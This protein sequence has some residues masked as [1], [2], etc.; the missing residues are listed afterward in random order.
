MAATSAAKTFR[1]KC[2]Q[3]IVPR[4]QACFAFIPHVIMFACFSLAHCWIE[5]T[6]EQSTEVSSF[7]AAIM[8]EVILC[9]KEVNE[10]ARTAAF[11]LVA[12][13]GET[14]LAHQAE[15]APV[16]TIDEFATVIAAGLAGTSSHMISATVLALARIVFQVT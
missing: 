4:L 15:Q 13:I 1:L 8:A 6:P 9:T 11:G 2:L 14:I 5:L 3:C 16:M 10:T 7:V 12:C